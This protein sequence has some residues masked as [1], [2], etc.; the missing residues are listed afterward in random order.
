MPTTQDPATAASKPL[1]GILDEASAAPRTRPDLQRRTELDIRLRTELRRLIP[2]VQA[3]ADRINHGTRA[4][5]SR[6]KALY[7]ASEELKRGLSPS[8]LAGCLRIGALARSVRTLDE[9]A[10]GES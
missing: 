2:L 9:F 7:D 8:P 6:D 1:P 3:Q 10:G 5:Y 4:W